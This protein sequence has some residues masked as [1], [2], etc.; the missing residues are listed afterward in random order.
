MGARF[1]N[2]PLL[3]LLIYSFW[4]R[5][6]F[7]SLLF[8]FLAALLMLPRIWRV[9][10]PG[11][12]PEVRIKLLDYVQG[13]A[14]RR[15]AVNEEAIGNYQAAFNA[16]R[17][18]WGNNIT[19]QRS[20]RGL[21]SAVPK[22]EQPENQ[23]GS[24]AQAGR[25]LLLLAGTNATDVAL[26]ARAEVQAGLSDRV[27]AVLDSLQELQKGIPPQLEQL[28]LMALFGAQRTAEFGSRIATNQT[29]QAEI[30]RIL[31]APASSELGASGDE[32]NF[33]LYCA[34]YMV[35]WGNLATRDKGLELLHAARQNR[36]TESL[37]YDLEFIAAWRKHDTDTCGDLLNQLKSLGKA[38]IHQYTDY[39]ALL[40][41]DHRTDEA[42]KDAQ[43]ANL[44][45]VNPLDAYRLARAE[46]ALNLWDDAGRLLQ[47]FT[48][49]IG[50]A[51]ELLI[52]RAD[53]LTRAGKWDDLQSLAIQM[54]L[55]PDTMDLLGGYTYYLE[56]MADW[57]TGNENAARDAF[58]R[59]DAT[60]FSK[61]PLLALKVSTDMLDVGPSKYPK[62]CH[63]EMGGTAAAASSDGIERQC[64]ILDG[65]AEMRL[66]VARE[67][68][69][70]GSRVQLLPAQAK[71]CDR[72]EQ[73]RR[74]PFDPA[75]ATG[76]GHFPDTATLPGVSAAH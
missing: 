40:I 38:K 37:A 8:V 65:A 17:A 14:L 64:G 21:L 27:A 57:N 7:L 20:M 26:I 3:R 76:R 34:A 9:T 43:Q 60:G 13:W 68:L 16:W 10:P 36:Q 52:L 55:Q 49:N 30:T 50:W 32:P 59:T 58:E 66:G 28:Y 70:D 71:R 2:W 35:G 39:W 11:F 67:F 46:I 51:A 41:D 24:V 25:W 63:R 29:I 22:L 6:A 1:A 73:L 54:R 4:F 74:R 48:E 53:V 18:A 45:P 47:R 12:R 61:A 56:G 69:F 62:G 33:P 75:P 44:V 72:D 42:R 15:T 31:K 5:L 23:M 19:D